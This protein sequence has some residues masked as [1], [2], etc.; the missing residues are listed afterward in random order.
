MAT[1]LQVIQIA[2]VGI[3]LALKRDIAI[4]IA[5]HGES[6]QPLDAIGKIKEDI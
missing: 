1:M 5:T 2:L 6:H 3:S 4:S